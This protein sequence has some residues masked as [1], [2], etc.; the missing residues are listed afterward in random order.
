MDRLNDS[1]V[2]HVAENMDFGMVYPGR[3][4][5]QA[6]SMLLSMSGSADLAD[7]FPELRRLALG[8]DAEPLPAAVHIYL[9]LYGDPETVR[10]GHAVQ[11]DVERGDLWEVIFIDFP[12]FGLFAV[13]DGPPPDIGVDISPF[14]EFALD[15][16]LPLTLPFLTLGFGT[17]TL[18][19]DYRTAGQL[20]TGAT[21]HT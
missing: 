4:M 11:G 17:S 5:R 10:A 15:H 2:P 14:A 20:G 21:D 19:C 3:F 13:V 16:R 7:R 12:P 18:P 8:G 9:V 1:P 6:I